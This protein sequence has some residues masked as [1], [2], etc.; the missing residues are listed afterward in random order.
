MAYVEIAPR[1]KGNKKFYDYVGG[2]LIAYAFKLGLIRGKGL[3]KGM[4]FF[5]VQESNAEDQIKL[6]GMY[7]QKY[8][9]KLLEKGKT[10]MVI[11]DSGGDDLINRYLNR[12]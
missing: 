11:T 4:L 2:C 1:N 8:N 10:T 6:M 3:Y 5:D 12:K 9:A 7:S